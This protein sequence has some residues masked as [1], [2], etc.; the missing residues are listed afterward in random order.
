MTKWILAL[1]FLALGACASKPAPVTAENPA[2]ATATEDRDPASDMVFALNCKLT[3]KGRP[4]LGAPSYRVLKIAKKVHGKWDYD[5]AVEIK[6]L[7]PTVQPW[8]LPLKS[9]ENGDEDYNDF[10]V[11][12]RDTHGLGVI[13]IQNQ[14]KWAALGNDKGSRFAYCEK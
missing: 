6:P 3:A 12:G 13:A 14:F 5:Y 7:N 1:S 11:D 2:P 8:R 10:V 9:N 4:P